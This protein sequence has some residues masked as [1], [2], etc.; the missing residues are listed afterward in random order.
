MSTP[1]FFKRFASKSSSNDSLGKSA[2]ATPTN[3]I[4][5]ERSLPQFSG[6]AERAQS[7][8]IAEPFQAQGVENP[9]SYVGASIRIAVL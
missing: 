6:L 4:V 9:L 1:N 5:L 2:D 8:A 7:A 3:E